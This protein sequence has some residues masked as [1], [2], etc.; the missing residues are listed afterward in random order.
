MLNNH[1]SYRMRPLSGTETRRPP[2]E[3]PTASTVRERTPAEASEDEGSIR[4]LHVDDDPAFGE[5][6][7]EFLSQDDRLTVI[8]ESD[9]Q[10]VLEHLQGSKESIDCIVSDYQMPGLNGVELFTAIRRM[11]ASVPFIVFTGSKESLDEITTSGVTDALVKGGASQH[12]QLIDRIR[13]A[14]AE[15]TP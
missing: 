13:S 4:V 9:P 14:V 3:V 15:V 6:T 1:S 8:S 11:D 10:R 2:A 12:R 5:L 7:A